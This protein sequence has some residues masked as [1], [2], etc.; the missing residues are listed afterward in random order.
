M[1]AKG[2]IYHIVRV[3]DIDTKIPTLQSIPVVKE[4]ADV[5]PDELPDIPVYAST[6]VG[7]SIMVDYVYH[8]CLVSIRVYETMFDLLLLNVMDFDLIL[9]RVFSSWG[10]P[11]F[12]MKKKD[13][14]MRMCIGCKQYNKVTINNK[15][16]LP[17]IDDLFDQ[18]WGARLFSKIDLRLG[19][20]QLKIK[21]SDIPRTA[22]KTLYW[23][24]DFLL[25]PFILTN[26]PATFMSLYSC[27]NAE[28]EQ[29]LW[30]RSDAKEV[31]IY[32]DCVLRLQGRVCVLNVDGLRE[33]ILE[34]AHSSWYSIHPGAT[35]IYHDLKHHYWWRRMKKDIVG[36][37]FR[38][39]NCQH[40]KYEHQKLGGLLQKIDIPEWKRE[41]VTMDFVVELP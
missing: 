34:E 9:G 7:D 13:D 30:M 1:I 11:V 32:D 14:S 17:C 21:A 33:L 4:Y 26:V 2:Y 15:Y 36:H 35:K 18:L 27:S 5:F 3:R 25:M 23:H 6:P 22:F 38:C 37:V 8:Y 12:L 41:S 28:H 10:A 40:V 19:Y 20:H 31:S 39:W 24:Y 29:H 16:P